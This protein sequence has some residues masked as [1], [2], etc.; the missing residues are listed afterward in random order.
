MEDILKELFVNYA[1]VAPVSVV[2][3]TGDG[4]NR[5]YYRMVA[6][7]VSLIGAVGTSVEENRAFQVY[8]GTHLFI[9]PVPTKKV[10]AHWHKP[11]LSVARS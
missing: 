7:A 10:C 1:G 6:D 2:K 3:L 4:S 5:A 9:P 11:F 8:D